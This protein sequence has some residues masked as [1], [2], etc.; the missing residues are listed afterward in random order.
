MYHCFSENLYLHIRIVL[1]LICI[2]VL[3]LHRWF[4][5]YID[6]IDQ[7]LISLLCL[8]TEHIC[9]TMLIQLVVEQ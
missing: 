2:Y 8:C 1:I 5:F 7:I 6:T 9:L 3:V 4:R